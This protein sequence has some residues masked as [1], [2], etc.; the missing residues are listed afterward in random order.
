MIKLKILDLWQTKLREDASKLEK[1]SLLYFNPRFMSLSQ[2][3]QLWLSCGNDRYQLNKACLQAKYLSGRSR[4][5]KL[6]SHFS[7][8]NS[9]FCQLHPHTRTVGDLLHEL[10]LCPVLAPQREQLFKF[11]DNLSAPF[12]VCSRILLNAKTTNSADFLQF[13]LDCSAVPQV[14]DAASEHGTGIYEILF[15]ATRTFCYT[16]HRTKRQIL[17]Q[18]S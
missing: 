6:M 9:P 8:E 4:T 16:I 3:H 15:K 11:W 13:L 5:E 17:D 18:W 1:N 12:P 14:I 10:V 7:K 2:P